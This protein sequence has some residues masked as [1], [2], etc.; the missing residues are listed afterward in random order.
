M[1]YSVLVTKRKCI[2]KAKC[3]LRTPLHVLELAWLSYT[4]QNY[5]ASASFWKFSLNLLDKDNFSWGLPLL[6]VSLF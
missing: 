2:M 1:R 6:D 5:M 3:C 4:I